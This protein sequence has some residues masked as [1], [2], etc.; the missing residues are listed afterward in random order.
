MC[1]KQLAQK[2]E[3]EK[4]RRI[5]SESRLQDV[6]DEKRD[7]EVSLLDIQDDRNTLQTR[8][9]DLAREKDNLETA[10]LEAEGVCDEFKD[11]ATKTLGD[12]NK[13]AMEHADVAK[14]RDVYREKRDR[15][16]NVI[17]QK[18]T[19]IERKDK[20]LQ[21]LRQRVEKL[22]KDRDNVVEDLALSR[23]QV[24]VIGIM[25]LGIRMC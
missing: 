15:A 24:P 19:E 22:E 3:N 11:E 5:E 18:N 6:L 20:M 1:R 14:E 16:M 9:F 2:L 13:L 12:Y 17:T 8:L 25:W 7:V 23:E 21:D 4:L 10:K